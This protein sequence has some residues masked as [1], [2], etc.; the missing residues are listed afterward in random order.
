M[1]LLIARGGGNKNSN[2]FLLY[3]ESRTVTRNPVPPKSGPPR[4]KVAAKISPPDQN[5]LPN[6]VPPSKLWSPSWTTWTKIGCQI[7]SP[8]SKLWSPSW[9]TWTKIGCQ[10]QS[11]Q[12]KLWSPSWTS[13][14]KIGCQIQ[15][16]Q[17]NYPVMAKMVPH[18]LV[19]QDKFWLPKLVPGQILAAKINPQDQF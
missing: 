17:A 8:Q 1:R 2:F 14:T 3:T 7:Q 15:S 4:P 18:K 13:R 10:I 11:P 12:S 5:W 16:P 6:T 19:P 9:T